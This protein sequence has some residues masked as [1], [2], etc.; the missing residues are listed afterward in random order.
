MTVQA[1][2]LAAKAR[3][4]MDEDATAYSLS[5][6]YD[7]ETLTLERLLL[8]L[9]PQAVRTVHGLCPAQRIGGGKWIDGGVSWLHLFPG[10]GWVLLPGD[11]MRLVVFEM[12][13]WATPVYSAI[14]QGT[15]EWSL[16]RCPYKGLRGTPT[17]PKCFLVRRPE[18]MA[19]EFHSCRTTQAEIS[20]GIYMPEPFIDREGGIEIED[21]CIDAAAWMLASL[22]FTA[23]GETAQAQAA[24]AQAVTALGVEQQPAADKPTK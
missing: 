18:G 17:K 6:E 14:A 20:Q 5:S 9:V 3:M 4:L 15:P 22:A 16:R 11:F 12:D 7:T 13:D 2:K 23:L 21:W 8:S 19:L 1:H 24:M 10:S